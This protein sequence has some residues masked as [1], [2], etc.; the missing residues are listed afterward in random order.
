[1]PKNMSE[2]HNDRRARRIEADRE[3]LAERLARSMP[4]D[5][6]ATLQP[7]VNLSRFARPTELHH[8]F[9]EACFCVIAQGAKTLT[10]GEDVLRYD[11]AH[12]MIAT[13]GV[14]M[15]AQVV[16]ASP[17]RP[18]LA[19]RLELSPSVVASVMVESS[20][21]QPRDDDGGVRAVAI[22]PLDADLLDATVRL[23]RLIERPEEYPALAP[24]VLREIVYRLLAGPQGAR[25]RHLAMEGGHAHRIV[26]A[27]AKLRENFDK[28][29]RIEAVAKQLGMSASGFHAHFKAVTAMSPLQFQKSLRLQE[30]RRLMVGEYLDAAEAGYR[31]GYEDPAYFSRDYKRHFGEAPMR[32]VERLRELATA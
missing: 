21:A 23:V 16:E 27:V 14:P 30:A 25:M 4:R 3:E 12:Y 32:D 17:E 2:D 20:L 26:R 1:M 9:Y 31:V 7:G 24:L 15:T 18:Y 6:T 28:P 19:I 5:G 10:L 11:P 13:V 22:S 8:G 29:L